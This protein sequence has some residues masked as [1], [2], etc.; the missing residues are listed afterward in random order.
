MRQHATR[1]VA[2]PWS[3]PLL[4]T[5]APLLLLSA[6]MMGCPASAPIKPERARY[7]FEAPPQAASLAQAWMA[8]QHELA[9][10]ASDALAQDDS[11]EALFLRAEH[12][13]WRGDVEQ[14]VDLHLASLARAPS[15]PLARFAAAR[16]SELHD[17]A[18]DFHDRVAP[19]LQALRYDQLHPMTAA[20]VSAIAQR[21]AW[22]AWR[23]GPS[24]Q[25]FDASALGL[26]TR[27]RHSAQMSRWRLLDF[28]Q[29][30]APESDAA[31]AP[32][33]LSPAYAK[34]EPA[35]QRDTRR[36]V[37][38]SISL[39]PQLGASGV[40]YLETFASVTASSPQT[41]WLYGNFPAQTRVFID[42]VEVLRHD[43]R[44]YEPGRL[45][46][47][48]KLSPGVHRV[49]VKLAFQASYR[50]WFDLTFLNR[51]GSPLQGSALTFHD[52]P[53]KPDSPR[54]AV[55]LLSALMRPEDL[56]PTFLPPEQIASADSTSLYL[57]AWSAYLARQPER[58][59][60]PFEE[61]TRRHPQWAVLHGLKSLQVRSLWELPSRVRD[62]T[63]LQQLRAGLAKDPQSLY[64]LIRVANWLRQKGKADE[65]RPLL[66]AARQAAVVTQPD[67][68]TR[69]LHV[70]P[71]HS[72]ASWLQQQGW[73]ELAERAWRE[74]L[75]YSPTN[76]GAASRL[77]S[78]LMAR[79]LYDPPET[80]GVEL[81]KCP[82]LMEDY[83]R[84]HPDMHQQRLDLLKRE[85]ARYPDQPQR[86][87]ELVAALREDGQQE[88]ADAL[89]AQT[90]KRSP[91]STAARGELVSQVLARQGAQAALDVLEQSV[92]RFGASAWSVWRQAAL[93]AELP[94]RELMRDGPAVARQI[95]AQEAAPQAS[96]LVAALARDE[97]YYAIDFAA[98]HY[99][100]DGSSITLTHTMVRVMTKNAIDRFGEVNIP[101]DAKVIVA[102]T[103]KPDGSTL[104]PEQTA[105]KDTLSMPG[106][107]EGDFVELAYVEFVSP[108]ALARTHT[109][110]TRFFFRMYDIS[111][112]HSEF[113]VI[114]PP[115]DLLR[116]HGAPAPQPF[117]HQGLPAVRFVR[118][119]SPRPRAEPRVVNTEEFLPWVQ[120]VRPG[121]TLDP[122]EVIRRDYRE[123][124]LDS[125]KLSQPA[126]AQLQAWGQGLKGLGGQ[127]RAKKLYYDVLAHFP[128][129]A[130][131]GL[132]TDLSHALATREGSPLLVM[133]KAFE[134]H[135][136]KADLYMVKSLYQA[137]LEDPWLAAQGFSGPLLRVQSPD[138]PGQSWW[139]SPTSAQAMFHT[140]PAAYK[141]QPALCITCDSPQLQTI[142]H[143]GL[144]DDPTQ[145]TLQAALDDQ[146]QLSGQLTQVFHGPSASYVRGVL[147]ERQEQTARQKLAGAL[148]G[149]HLAGAQL[150]SFQILDE[151][152]LDK[153]LTLTIR[154]VRPQL[155]RKSASGELILELPLFPEPV[156]SSYASLPE[157]EAPLFVGSESA[158]QN[159]LELTLPPGQTP[160]LRS[161]SGRWSVK[162][163]HGQ[164]DREVTLEGE[165]LIVRSSMRMPMQRV[166]VAQ[167]PAFQRWATEVEQSALLILT[168]K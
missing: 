48:I 36:Y 153:P 5:L 20:T 34:D 101:S 49:L 141:G 109:L 47:R 63:A 4:F 32:S 19:T 79:E 60:P 24:D 130:S 82:S 165:R 89:L 95:A 120:L 86:Q 125:L 26:P 27:W 163:A 40:Y 151:P 59:D 160:T 100:P 76:C 94:L 11:P 167:Y 29:P 103:V 68:S 44:D 67:G 116:A 57:M 52:Q 96:G 107:A 126:R 58:F 51:L 61:L 77:Q 128:K 43:E 158:E 166:S 98:A 69:V 66:E 147:R 150:V 108:H 21:V 8:G 136:F 15:H 121:L 139:L 148:L 155:A 81:T 12:A 56:E 115:G 131:G 84:A 42:G 138:E 80:L 55:E 92:A 46:R 87:L 114:N 133:L 72:W 111:S 83:L 162:S 54:G 154:F 75:A 143:T 142:P 91:R 85:A 149:Q 65:V 99:L 14:A 71:L 73:Q 145:L 74:A 105:G 164:L 152:D 159:L 30:Y 23:R 97:A 102:R 104:A 39:S 38:S 134:L 45:M 144:R 127:A 124:L 16:L 168:L 35:N 118:K 64:F 161:R 50:D 90:L 18:L 2:A 137:P 6:L 113:V 88:A 93:K 146:G 41:Y 78:I 117:E 123:Q 70:M 132:N 1:P 157:R 7:A 135:G 22:N 122:L 9:L 28:D 53:P 31:L 140:F 25:P 17:E 62:A 129:P 106:L 33:Y 156:A 119:D 10:Q 3:S 112:L 37:S 110:G 13:Y